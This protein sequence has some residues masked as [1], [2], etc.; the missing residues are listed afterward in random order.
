MFKK[1]LIANRGAI[2]CRILRTIKAMGIGPVAIY[3]EADANAPHVR[4]ADEAYCVGTPPAAESYLRQ[5][6]ILEIARECGA[7]AIHP[8]YGFLSENAAFAAACEAAGIAFI[9]PTPEQMRQFGL[10]HTA[11]ELAQQAGL[12]L[13]PG[14]DLL[15]DLPAAL[16]A[17]ERIG[18]PVMLK[19]T[20]GGGGI[21]MRRCSEARELEESFAAV[22][23]LAEGNFRNAGVF[24]E[25]FVARA[26][27]IEV[28]IFGD[29]AGRVIALGERDC[30]VQRRNQKVIEE[31]PAP[32]LSDVARRELHDAAARL[33]RAVGYRSAGTVE[34]VYDA[35]AA[36]FYFLEVNTRLQVEHGVTEEV[37]GIDLVEWMIRTAAG[38][39]PDLESFRFVPRGHAIQA[40]VYAEDPARNFRPSSGLLTRVKLPQRQAAGGLRVDAWI[41][42]GT[43]VTGFYDPMLAKIIARGAD[44]DAAIGQ[45]AAALDASSIDGIET[46]LRYLSSVLRHPVA[47]QPFTGHAVH[48]SAGARHTDHGAGLAGKTGTVGRGRATVRTHGCAGA[49]PGESRRRQSGR[50]RRAGNDRHRRHAALRRR[51]RRRADRRAPG[52]DARR[53]GG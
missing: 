38:E 17:A 14:T 6:R 2:A 23:R 1:V 3:S 20:A 49:A 35:D 13:L 47:G 26:R 41:E 25:K 22:Q 10:K 7:E 32:G 43:E 30:S 24:L 12:P 27:H 28:Q 51:R 31:S 4:D 8:G 21:G 46:N 53:C 15:A 39:P 44:R 18:Y 11:R 42:A 9:G 52:G 16:A 45:L 19:S 36:R 33:G 29:G 40:R 5:E 48:R 50:R 34:F 37:G